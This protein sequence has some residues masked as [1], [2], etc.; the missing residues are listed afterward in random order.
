MAKLIADFSSRLEAALYL[1]N[2]KAVD[3]AA[4]TGISE[5]VISHY[6][7]GIRKP[8]G[9][10]LAILSHALQVEPG[11]LMG[12]DVPMKKETEEL[13]KLSREEK[14]LLEI[15]RQCDVNSKNDILSYAVYISQRG[16]L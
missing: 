14:V 6:R 7:N 9:D 12:Y 8:N 16:K 10:K 1:N 3:L 4:K 2:M 5:G 11:W 15:Y 13:I